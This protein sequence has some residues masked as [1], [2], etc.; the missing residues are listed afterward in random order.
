MDKICVVELGKRKQRFGASVI[1]DRR[2][3]MS[4]IIGING[5]PR[6]GWNSAKMLD[7]ALEG[8][9]SAGAEVKRVDLYSLSYTGCRSCFACKRL[10][11]P[12]FGRCA[13]RDDLYPLL[14]EILDSDGLVL[15]CPVYFG[16]VPGMVRSFC[17]RLWFPSHTYSTDGSIAYD[18]H[19]RVGLIYTMNVP[20]PGLYSEMISSEQEK[21]DSMVGRTSV[22]C[23]GDTLQFDDYSRYSS[24]AFDPVRKKKA[25]EELFPQDL[26]RAFEFGRDLL[27]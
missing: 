5:S 27:G 24:S 1:Y 14:S 8:A 13:V 20:D 7:S 6:T 10:G 18:L 15:S 16:S 12:G 19:L 3:N 17:E 22:L 25:H 9:A 11:S 4:R 21:F 26:K 23:A 2:R